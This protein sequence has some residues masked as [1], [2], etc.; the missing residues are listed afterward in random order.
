ML[1]HLTILQCNIPDFFHSQFIKKKT[2]TD[3]QQRTN[4]IDKQSNRVKNFGELLAIESQP[5]RILDLVPIVDWSRVHQSGNST[6][7]AK[8]KSAGNKKQKAAADE[9][10]PENV[11]I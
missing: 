3:T 4:I 1:L 9:K 8:K 6:L 7:T 10:L 11:C 2:S 5:K